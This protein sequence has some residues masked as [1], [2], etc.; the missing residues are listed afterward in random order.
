MLL[1]TVAGL[2]AAA[3]VSLGVASSAPAATV[4]IDNS[5]ANRIYAEAIYD[6]SDVSSASYPITVPSTQ[7]LYAQSS[8]FDPGEPVSVLTYDLSDA[9]F[10]FDFSHSL[11]VGSVVWN[12]D[13][14]GCYPLETPSGASSAYAV[15]DIAFV[16]LTNVD[17]QLSGFFNISGFSFNGVQ[18]AVELCDNTG[19][20]ICG[21]NPLLFSTNQFSTST[22]NESFVLGAHG[23]DT[24]DELDGSLTG[25]LLAF[26]TYSIHL[27]AAFGS[28]WG[29]NSYDYPSA[30]GEVKLAFV[31][32]PGTCGLVLTGI[33]GLAARRSRLKRP[34]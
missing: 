28:E 24:T 27:Y 20:V 12:C 25:S 14:I 17:Y 5:F 8:G 18:L 16:P 1:R 9:S 33:A 29:V 15:A 21:A 22:M 26:H 31:P 34:L 7:T 10:S 13:E 2:L 4:L 6:Y 30:T 19:G 11:A 32:E 23:G 3:L